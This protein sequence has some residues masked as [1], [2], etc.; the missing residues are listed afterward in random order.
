MN[1]SNID[2]FFSNYYHWQS[3]RFEYKILS[4]KKIEFRYCSII[5]ENKGVYVALSNAL[6]IMLR[7]NIIKFCIN[8]HLQF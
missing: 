5:K 8:V 3:V 4:K 2:L 7:F 1:S 6:I